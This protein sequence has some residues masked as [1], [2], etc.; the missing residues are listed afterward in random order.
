MRC[1]LQFDLP[2]D[3]MKTKDKNLRGFVYMVI[4]RRNL[5]SAQQQ[6]LDEICARITKQYEL[7]EWMKSQIFG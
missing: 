1:W 4:P 5:D 6:Q 2:D 7:K 3:K